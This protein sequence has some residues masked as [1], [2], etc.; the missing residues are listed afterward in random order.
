VEKKNS[1]EPS[2]VGRGA[3][4]WR[5]ARGEGCGANAARVQEM[6]QCCWCLRWYHNICALINNRGHD[7][8]Q[9]DDFLCPLCV[10]RSLDSYPPRGIPAIKVRAAAVALEG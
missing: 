9:T 8:T 6:V 4:L 1:E 10:L 7:K 2:E 3:W 5:K